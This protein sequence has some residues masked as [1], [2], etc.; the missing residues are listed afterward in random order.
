MEIVGRK[1]QLAQIE[2]LLRSK[3]AEFVAVTGRRRTPFSIE[4]I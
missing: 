4:Y 2:T 3:K 1:G